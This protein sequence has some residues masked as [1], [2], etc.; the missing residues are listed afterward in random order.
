MATETVTIA[1][2]PVLNTSATAT[3]FACAP[4]NS[5]NTSTVTVF[6]PGGGGTPPYLYS[7]DNSNFQSSN[8]FE[9]A[10][11]GVSQ[12][13]NVYVRDANGCVATDFVILEPLN[14]FDATVAQDI[15]ISCANP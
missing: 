5:V 14:S 1:E 12:T 2:P 13:I 8:T 10:D 3:P 7:I 6:V 15:A 11:T 4:D 9:V